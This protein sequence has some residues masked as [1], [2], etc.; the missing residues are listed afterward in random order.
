[1]L[2]GHDGGVGFD[3]F[4]AYDALPVMRP[5]HSVMAAT[6]H[7]CLTEK[8]RKGEAK[9]QSLHDRRRFKYQISERQFVKNCRIKVVRGRKL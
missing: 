5:W 7:G 9:I 1:M 6:W 3:V 4:D 8:E 2:D